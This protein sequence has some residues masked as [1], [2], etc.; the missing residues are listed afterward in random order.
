V[1]GTFS[2]RSLGPGV[3]VPSA[4]FAVGRGAIAPAVVLSARELGASLGVAGLI[5]S[6]IGIGH[7]LADLP[8]GAIA[9]RVGDRR[10]MLWSAL[11]TAIALCGCLLAT[12]V[13]QLGLA[14]GSV[15][16]A[17][18][19]WHVA[20]HTYLTEVV[21]YHL[22]ARA[23][24]SAG[25]TERVGMFVGPFLGAAT[26]PALGPSGA[27]WVFLVVTA[28]A[29]AALLLAPD[30]QPE[31]AAASGTPRPGSARSGSLLRGMV[32]VVR[33]HRRLLCT[34]GLGVMVLGAVRASRQVVIPLWGEQLELAPATIS[35]VFGIAGGVDMLLF[36]PAGK[37]MDVAGRRA[38]AV[39]CLALLGGSHLLLP[40]THSLMAFAVVA[41]VMGIG[42]GI[43][44]GIIM[45]IGADVSPA[46]RRA[47]FLGAWR[48]VSDIGT[49]A[50][51]SVISAV[52]VLAALGPALMVMGGIGCLGALAMGRWIPRYGIP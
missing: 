3:Y 41:M 51:P 18:T 27:Y 40:F 42:N 39:P 4:L 34:L 28:V 29:S 16:V 31:R 46:E 50:G 45:T 48:L 1:S 35:V 24:S 19:V 37:V 8:A 5:V 11:L 9:A 10:A 25:G 43:G 13:W 21:P 6:L 17:T 44:S 38:V 52:T 26:M 22:R 47:E 30:V 32:Q 23:M 2:L 14:I 49:G 36:Y 20:R 7:I 15:G 12:S 33:D